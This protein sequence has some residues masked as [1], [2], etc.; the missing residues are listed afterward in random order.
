MSAYRPLRGGHRVSELVPCPGPGL[1]GFRQKPATKRDEEGFR[2]WG[3][4]VWGSGV[5]V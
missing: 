5:R 4:R 2:V 1:P 3:F